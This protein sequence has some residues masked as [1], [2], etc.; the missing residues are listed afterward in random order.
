MPSRARRSGPPQPGR[1]QAPR[2]GAGGRTTAREGRRARREVRLP[3]ERA[4][5][6]EDA[7]RRTG[8]GE[9]RALRRRL[10]TPS[11]E[12]GWACGRLASGRGRTGCPAALPADAPR[13]ATR[14]T[15]RRKSGRSRQRGPVD[16][17][18]GGGDP[19]DGLG[20][21]EGWD[22]PIPVPSRASRATAGCRSPQG[23]AS[24][25][26]SARS[27]E[28]AKASDAAKPASACLCAGDGAPLQ[29]PRRGGPSGTWTRGGAGSGARCRA[30]PR[31]RPG[32]WTIVS[33]NA[34]SIASAEPFGASTTAISARAHAAGL[35]IAHDPGPEP[36][37]LGL[38][39]P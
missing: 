4:A 10:A 30:C 26:R 32:V 5:P 29:G 38:Q 2:H 27:R 34:A 24:N 18:R 3:R 6:S 13:F 7:G 16:P 9:L 11:C 22:H 14:S 15:A 17:I 31:P 21:G 36:R 33:G 1:P 23:P 20:E 8:A 12:E 25:R 35:E 37:P 28:A 39:G 19:A